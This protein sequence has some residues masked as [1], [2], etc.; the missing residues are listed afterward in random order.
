M[1]AAM[2]DDSRRASR[3]PVT[4]GT[5]S[6]DMTMTLPTVFYGRDRRQR[7]QQGQQVLEE[8]HR[9]AG[10]FR[11]LGVIGGE[12][13]FLVENPHHCRDAYRQHPDAQDVKPG[14]PQDVAKQYP[15]QISGVVGQRVD[16]DDADGETTGEHHADDG[17]D[18]NAGAT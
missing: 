3:V 6:R 12:H 18:A 11:Y 8:P 2:I 16:D 17:V 10:G 7:H 13:Q 15:Q 5:T 4:D 9:H 14:S 1:L